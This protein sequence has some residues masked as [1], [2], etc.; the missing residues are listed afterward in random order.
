M[1]RFILIILIFTFSET[2]LGQTVSM[3]S[4]LR[5]MVNREVITRF[6]NYQTH[7]TSSYNRASV[8]PNAPGWFADSDGVFCIREETNSSGEKEWVL[9]EDTGAGVITK[10]WAVCFYY[11]MAD[12]TGA[13]INIYIDGAETPTIHTNF[14]QLV[15]GHDFVKAPLAA[16]TRRAGNLYLP[17]PYAKSCKIT[18]DKKVFYNSICYRRYPEGTKIESFSMDI[19]R[20]N[21][22]LVDSVNHILSQGVKTPLSQVE[23]R[24]EIILHPKQQVTIKL[25]KGERAISDLSINIGNG[26]VLRQ[27]VM[28]MIF[29]QE[30]TVWSPIGDFFSVGTGIIPYEMWER[31]VTSNGDMRCRWLMPYQKRAAIMFENLSDTIVRLK[32]SYTTIPYK[33]DNNSMYFHAHWESG[34]PTPGFPLFDYN[35]VE[36]DGKGIYVGDQFTVLNPAEGWWGEGD[37]KVWVDHEKFPSLFGTG[38]EDYYGWAGGIVPTSKDQFSEPFLANIRVAD[39]NS[40]GYNTCSRTRTLDA[41]PFSKHLQFDIES[42]GSMRYNWFHLLYAINTYWYAV[43]GATDNTRELKEYAS[44]APM[45]LDSLIRY[46]TQIKQQGYSVE[47]AIEAEN[48]T[49]Y[50][51]TEGAKQTEEIV[52]WGDKSGGKIKGFTLEE[53]ASVS[54]RLTELFTKKNLKICIVTNHAGGDI[55]IQINGQMIKTINLYSEHAA[56]PVIDLGTFNPIDNALEITFTA[57]K[58]T[59]LGI[60]YFLTE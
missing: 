52:I 60:D 5:E 31:A 42:S 27:T 36:I 45:T 9:M 11:N 34:E 24:D 2:V 10:I 46:N 35:M 33:W 55:D 54:V 6:P 7:Q 58:K 47:G 3:A 51:W 19:F 43:P 13:N 26:N 57:R 44:Q 59:Q 21:Q 14:F 29:D 49:T 41:I 56:M 28:K 4:L 53:K 16:E 20:K 23:K 12:T 8:S 50:Q 37:E 22:S 18:M 32:Y 30:T 48:L 17:I 1:Q 25:P 39:P 38:T 40:K 15:K